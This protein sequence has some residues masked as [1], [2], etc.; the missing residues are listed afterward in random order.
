MTDEVQTKL[1]TNPDGTTVEVPF[2]TKIGEDVTIAIPS[3]KLSIGR[4]VT[5][6][7]D[8]QFN[9]NPRSNLDDL[10]IGND[11]FIGLKVCL[12]GGTKI[13]SGVR[14]FANV[15]V[16]DS[17]EIGRETRIGSGTVIR[18]RVSIGEHVRIGSDCIIAEGTQIPSYWIIP[19]NY[20]VNPNLDGPPVALMAK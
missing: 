10:E 15:I 19:A 9:V 17:V 6:D 20:V 3:D 4:A 14:L 11:V 12:Q 13:G 16:R 7:H 1:H 18:A 2:D 5:I 8:V